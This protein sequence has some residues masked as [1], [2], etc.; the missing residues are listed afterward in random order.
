MLLNKILFTDSYTTSDLQY[1]LQ[2]GE[3]NAITGIK[4]LHH[5]QFE[6]KSLEVTVLNI[7]LNTGNF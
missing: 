3:N 5:P 6:V 2:G 7:S 4:E 1:F